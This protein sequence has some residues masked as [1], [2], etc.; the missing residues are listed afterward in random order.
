MTVLGCMGQYGYVHNCLTVWLGP[1]GLC[2][3]VCDQTNEPASAPQ[4]KL[5]ALERAAA[6]LPGCENTHFGTYKFSSMQR[7]VAQ[8]LL[9]ARQAAVWV[10]A[11]IKYIICDI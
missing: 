7:C 11:W 5:A 3:L 4:L 1:I 9:Q 2:T 8:A 6:L 10:A